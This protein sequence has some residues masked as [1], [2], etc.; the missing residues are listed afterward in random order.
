MYVKHDGRVFPCCQSYHLDG[1][2][3]GDLRDESLDEIFNSAK[4][5]GLRRL[6]AEGRA[7]EI[8]MCARCSTAVP[9]PL[10]VAG[11]LALHGKWVRRALPLVEG[12]VY[13]A[14]LS[15]LLTPSRELVQ[16]APVPAKKE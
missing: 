2:P 7:G 9:H 6:H 8:D 3:I 12:L 1:E 11:S 14:K 4:M 5:R 10:L 16:I 13:R 15:K